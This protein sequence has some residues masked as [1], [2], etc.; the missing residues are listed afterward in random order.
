VLTLVRPCHDDG[1]GVLA[2]AEPFSS[3]GS[4][5]VARTG[6]VV[7]HG[8]TGSPQSMRPW[9]EALAGEGYAVRLPRLPGHGTTWQELQATRWPDWYA[10]VDRAYLDLQQRCDTV[11]AVGLSMGGTLAFR[12]AEQHADTIA[13]IV[14]V[15]AFLASRDKRLLLL[16][17]LKQIVPSLPGIGSDIKKAGVTELAYTR[18]P[19][20]AVAS[21]A[22]MQKSVRADLRLIRCPVLSYRSREDHV[23]DSS[24]SAVLERAL[25]GSGRY[26]EVVLEDSYHV[27]T[28]DNDFP[29]IVAGSLDLIRSGGRTAPAPSAP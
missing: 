11:F 12:L 13:G 7:C 22:E 9:A 4:G 17:V 18:T 1:V 3:D 29:T 24:T 19:L 28:L 5:A 15:N 8:F 14:T 2:G 21:L 23:V 6:V 25:G 27:A 20:R 16:P 10:E 26:T